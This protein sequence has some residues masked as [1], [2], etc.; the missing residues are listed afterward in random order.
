MLVFLVTYWY[1]IAIV[2]VV[3]GFYIA[4][5][6]KGTAKSTALQYLGAAEGMVFNSTETKLGVVSALG[7]KALPSVV[8]AVVSPSAFDVIV[9][10]CY[11]EA[12][13]L[14]DDLHND[15]TVPAT[16]NEVKK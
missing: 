10:A 8:K 6:L 16:K 1:V 9:T 7:Y 2:L 14:V 12:K 15:P 3:L 13:K 5:Q 11:A 4:R